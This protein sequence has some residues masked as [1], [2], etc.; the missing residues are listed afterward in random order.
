MKMYK[1]FDKDF[2][3]RGMQF[4]VGKT[5]EES[6]ARLCDSGFHACEHPLD[7]FRYYAPA[8]SR[9]AEVELDGVTDEKK[10]DTKRAGTKITIVAEVGLHGLID[11]AV[12]FVFSKATWSDKDKATGDQGAASATGYRGAASATGYQGAASATGYQGAASA[13]GDRG[14]ASATGDRGAASATGDQGAASATGDQGAASA[15]GKESCAMSLGI[16]AKAKASLGSWITLAEWKEI[17]YGWH[18]VDVKTRKVD[19]KH[20]KPNTWY[21]LVGGKFIESEDD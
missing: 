13:T 17:D 3:C 5:Y 12:K 21:S 16:Y 11:A 8:G 6:I 18:R 10:D 15:T 1:G 14:A 9:F 2:R 7:V 4:V 20:I 19:G